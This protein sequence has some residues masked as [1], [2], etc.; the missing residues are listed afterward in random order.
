ML[1]STHSPVVLANVSLDQIL[2]AR[3]DRS[4]AVNIVSGRKHPQLKEWKGRIDL[5]ALLATGALG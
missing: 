4:G 2:C 1:I 3:L 5:G